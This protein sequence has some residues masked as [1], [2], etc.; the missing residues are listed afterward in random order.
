MQFIAS[1]LHPV[2][3]GVGDI[4]PLLAPPNFVPPPLHL[5]YEIFPAHTGFHGFSNVVHQPEFPALPLPGGPVFPVGHLSSAPLIGGQNRELMLHTDLVAD[6]PKLPQSGGCLVELH[7]GFKADGVDHEV[8][9]DVLGIT[10]GGYL[11][12]M[13]RPGLCGK[14]QTDGVGLLIG[15]ILLRRKGLNVLV[16]IDAIQ[17]VISGLGSEKFHEG[18]GAVAVQSGYVS[19]PSFRVGSLVL[20]LTI[21]HDCL[22]GADVLLGFLDVGYSCQPL[23]PMRTSSS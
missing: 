19:N 3:A 11:H 20:P 23:P 14:L 12:L 18:I 4:F 6:L 7:P 1:A 5:P 8:G 17:L 13:P 9:M 2:G 22:H 10:V 16:E 21:P 15:D